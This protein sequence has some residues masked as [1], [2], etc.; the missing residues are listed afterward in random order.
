MLLASFTA[1]WESLGQ[2]HLPNLDYQTYKEIIM[3]EWW[4]K[5]ILELLLLAGGQ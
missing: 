2:I 3:V 5:V 1:Q 4:A